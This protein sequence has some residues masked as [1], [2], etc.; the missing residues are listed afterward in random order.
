MKLFFTDTSPY[1]RKVRVVAHELGL[2]DRLTLEFLRPTPYKADPLLSKQNPLSKIPALVLDD[3][4]SLYDSP[5]ICEYLDTLHDGRPMCPRAGNERWA[6]LRTQALTDGI[7]E[8]CILVFYETS[9]RPRELHYEAWLSGQREKAN[10]GLDELERLAS[11]FGPD[12]DL[13]QIC[14]GVTLGWLE[15]R[16]P[17]GDVRASR[18]EL[19]RWFESF[20]AR[21]SMVSTAPPRS[22]V[23]GTPLTPR[24]R[25][26]GC[27]D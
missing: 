10:Q 25:R 13:A 17:L 21:P 12:V 19:A 20:R 6:T 11:D 27:A 18:P 24:R 1:V 2:A 3:G 7:L 26:S 15:L 4:T 22:S 5:V 9:Q 16:N 23:R 14:A 8:A